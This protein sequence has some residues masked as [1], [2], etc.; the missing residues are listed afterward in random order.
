MGRLKTWDLRLMRSVSRRDSALFDRTLPA[1]TRVADHGKLW[2]AMAGALAVVPRRTPRRAALRGLAS[3]AVASGTANVIAKSL[4]HRERP[5]LEQTPVVRQ[6]RRPPRTSSFPSGHSASAAAFAT[7][8][9]LENP[10]LA[11][12]IAGLAVGVGLSR[13]VTGVHYPSDVVAGACLGVSAAMVTTR[14]SPYRT[15]AGTSEAM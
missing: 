11:L 8:V 3:L 2:F 9:A 1:L 6:L 13:V 14:W 4:V 12:P 15:P 10:W 5:A 7:G